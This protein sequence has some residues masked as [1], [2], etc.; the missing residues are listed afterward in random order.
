MTGSAYER[1]TVSG[2]TLN[3]RTAAMLSQAEAL[4]RV[5]GG[6]GPFR[7]VQGSYNGGGV[8]ASGGTHDGGGAFDIEIDGGEKNWQHAQW[9]LRLC[10]GASWE[11]PFIANLWPHHNHTIVIGDK[12]MS[13][14]AAA[15]VHDYYAGLDGL[16]DHA[17]DHTPHPGHIPVFI[18]P[19]RSVS[20][21]SVQ[22]EAKK[23]R[24]HRATSGVKHIQRALNAKRGLTLTVDGIYG[25]HTKAAFKRY[26]HQIGANADGVPGLRSL[27]LLG[28]A[29]FNVKS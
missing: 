12:Q 7:L 23:T 24:G 3:R 26:E 9:C 29:R 20:L 16:A 5:T 8:A 4:F 25:R 13:A 18:Y 21:G 10:G 2:Q 17:P 27:S 28:A 14:A 19:A 11:R 6:H 15:Q 22:A 1:I